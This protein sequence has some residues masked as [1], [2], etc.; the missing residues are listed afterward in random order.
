MTHWLIAPVVLPALLAPPPHS[1]WAVMAGRLRPP[2]V[3]SS[4]LSSLVPPLMWKATREPEVCWM[5]V[6]CA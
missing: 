2:E 4:R 6:G 3:V 1:V 5:V